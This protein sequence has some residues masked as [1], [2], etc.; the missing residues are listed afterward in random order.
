MPQLTKTVRIGEISG[1]LTQ[2]RLLNLDGADMPDEDLDILRTAFA[3]LP[4][5]AEVD[6]KTEY[7]LWTFVLRGG[8]RSAEAETFLLASRGGPQWVVHASEQ[9]MHHTAM[10]GG[11][12]RQVA[13]GNN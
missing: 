4:G 6:L 2:M 1:D 12:S 3:T 5:D 10:L 8:Q 9:E 7:G 11:S 13:V